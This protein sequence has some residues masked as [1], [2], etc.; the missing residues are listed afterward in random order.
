MLLGFLFLKAN[1]I[2]FIDF[3]NTGNGVEAPTA[4]IVPPNTTSAD[5]NTNNAPTCP[6][7][8]TKATTKDAIPTMKKIKVVIYS[9][10]SLVIH[11]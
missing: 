10:L 8:I 6:P 2:I 4:P 5:E 1:N 3:L 7:S 11:I 9:L